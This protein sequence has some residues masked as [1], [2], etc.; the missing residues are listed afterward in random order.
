MI[1]Y[2]TG[3]RALALGARPGRQTGTTNDNIDAWFCGYNAALVGVAWIASIN[4]DAGRQRNGRSC[5]V[6]DLDRLHREGA[7]GHAE[8]ALLPMPDGVISVR[9]NQEPGCATTREL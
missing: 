8:A 9:I 3:T 4:R 6:A 7:Q 2:G 5:R 1:A